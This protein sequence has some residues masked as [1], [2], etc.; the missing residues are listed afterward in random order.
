[1]GQPLVL[2][3]ALLLACADAA[4][5]TADVFGTKRTVSTACSNP[6]AIAVVDF[7]GDADVDVLA[8]GYAAGTVHILWNERYAAAFTAYEI[9]KVAGAHGV[10]AFDVDGDAVMDVLA[11]GAL[12]NTVTWYTG[13]Y[14]TPY[15]WSP[16]VVAS[17]AAQA[18]TVVAGDVDGD[19]DVDVVVA[20]ADA[21]TVSWYQNAGDH[22]T[23]S[24]QPIASLNIPVHADLVDMDGDADLDVVAAAYADGVVAWRGAGAPSPP[25]PPRS[26]ERYA[27][28]V[29]AGYGRCQ[30]LRRPQNL[31][32]LE[33]GKHG[34]SLRRRRRRRRRRSGLLAARR[35]L[36]SLRQRERVDLE[37]HGT[38][39]QGGRPRHDGRGR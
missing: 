36:R 18:R 16:T 28:Q 31:R 29:R 25:A 39:V 2:V 6:M 14:W 1:M 26:T 22:S 24:E 11:A 3:L 34:R 4:C 9:A 37:A 27:S 5:D 23:F 30:T 21:G 32:V 15:A 33:R 13:A 8:A 19:G 20:A 12:S 10:A 35:R 7:D 17:D 38:R